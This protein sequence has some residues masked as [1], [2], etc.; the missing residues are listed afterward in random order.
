MK[1]PLD[2]IGDQPAKVSPEVKS[3]IS[4]IKADPIQSGGKSNFIQID[5]DTYVM[6]YNL[7]FS[8][9]SVHEKACIITCLQQLG[10]IPK[11]PLNNI[12][13]TQ[14]LPPDYSKLASAMGAFNKPAASPQSSTALPISDMR[15]MNLT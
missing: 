4:E 8:N 1:N 6:W 11:P 2:P 15:V 12:H 7:T 13:Q 9:Y 10:K 3:V 14:V 5:L